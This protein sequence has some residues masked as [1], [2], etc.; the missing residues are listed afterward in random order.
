MKNPTKKIKENKIKR[1]ENNVFG[2]LKRKKTR[3]KENDARE[4]WEHDFRS[5]NKGVRKSRHGP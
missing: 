3:N 4:S 5:N 1:E 2:L